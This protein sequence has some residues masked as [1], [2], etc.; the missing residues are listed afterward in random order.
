MKPITRDQLK[1]LDAA[2]AIRFDA[3]YFLGQ[4]R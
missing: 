1:L 4:G 3:N 2:E